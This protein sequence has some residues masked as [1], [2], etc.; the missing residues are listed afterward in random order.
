MKKAQLGIV[1]FGVL[2]LFLSLPANAGEKVAGHFFDFQD[3]SEMT[4]AVPDKP[5]HSLKQ[6]TSVWK[7]TGTSDL[8][9]FWA[10]AVEQQEVVGT[11]IK[12]RG[13]GT[14]HYDNGDVA[15]VVWEGTANVTPKDA[16][17]FDMTAQGTFT[18]LGGTGKHNVKGPGT[19][20]CKFNQS[21]GTCDWQGEADYSSM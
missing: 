19:Y 3:L 11:D 7:S 12:S 13:Y 21:G 6:I 1:S 14:S 10:S 18:W 16:G 9:T 17:A 4:S 15:N 5:G 8:A 2:T 20:S